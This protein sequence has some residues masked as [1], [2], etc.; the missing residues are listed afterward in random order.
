[1]MNTRHIYIITL[2][3][4][5]WQGCMPTIESMPYQGN[6]LFSLDDLEV[7]AG[8]STLPIIDQRSNDLTYLLSGIQGIATLESIDSTLLLPKSLRY[9]AGVYQVYAI[10]E[11]TIIDQINLTIKAN[12]PHGQILTYLG[13]K[14]TAFEDSPGTMLTSIVTD[15]FNNMI[16]LPIDFTYTFLGKRGVGKQQE[17]H[18]H[19]YFTA[20][21]FPPY[22]NDKVLVGINGPN[23]LYSSELP[24]EGSSGCATAA[25]VDIP[26]YYPLADGRQQFVVEVNA[27]TDREGFEVAEGTLLSIIIAGNQSVEKYESLVTNG[28]A[29]FAIENPKL[30]G[31]Y[32]LSVYSC[33]NVIV[34]AKPLTFEQVTTSLQYDWISKDKL[35]IG[36]VTNNLNQSLPNGSPVEVSLPNCSKYSLPPISLY[37]G[38]ATL[39][40]NDIYTRCEITMLSVTVGE[41]TLMINAK[42]PL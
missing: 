3:A 30:S 16:D 42:K 2:L 39:N 37:D 6:D 9:K 17:R 40:L 38:F 7:I 1:M 27:I 36:P 33:G 18:D 5:S 41:R 11:N 8:Q 20:K 25:R 15:T 22:N 32:T 14:T 21:L 28:S 31:T 4:L 12:E 26:L 23:H 35:R 10:H 24:L 19:E 13:P 34:A 29:V